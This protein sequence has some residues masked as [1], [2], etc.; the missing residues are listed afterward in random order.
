MFNLDPGVHFH[1]VVTAV[2]VVEKFNRPDPLVIQLADRLLRAPQH[3]L[4]DVGRQDDGRRF[5][6]HLLVAGL[7]RTVPF[8]QGDRVPITVRDNLDFN[9]ARG[10]QV[11]FQIHPVVVKG[12]DR[13]FLGRGKLLRQI[14]HGIN[15][16]HP[17]TAPTGAGFQ[18][19]R[20]AN[21]IGLGAGFRQSRH[22]RLAPLDHRQAGLFHR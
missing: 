22:D 9:V 2:G 15:D 8:P 14:G 10:R 18:H 5:F 16:P 11:L 13:F 6:N 12:G 1:E 21:L 17:L 3:F 7:N 20:V 4:A 19:H